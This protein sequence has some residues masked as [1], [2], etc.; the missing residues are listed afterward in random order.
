MDNVNYEYVYLFLSNANIVSGNEYTF[1][2]LPQYYTNQ[3]AS[4]CSVCLADCN[5][6]ADVDSN[7]LIQYQNGGYNYL[8]NENSQIVGAYLGKL[9]VSTG[10]KTN[11]YSYQKPDTIKVLTTPRPNKITIRLYD[12]NA[13][14]IDSA[15]VNSGMICL[16]YD[17]IPEKSA[18]ED[19]F[20]S[21]YKTL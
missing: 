16:R 19:Y 17:Y 9:E 4:K 13:D 8:S 15:D 12:S 5:I 10:A 3:R 21:F 7:I 2:L 20:R 14:P 11:Y 1:Y 18:I 6:D